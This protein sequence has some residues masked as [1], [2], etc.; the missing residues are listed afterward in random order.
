MKP[1]DNAALARMIPLEPYLRICSFRTKLPAPI[2]AIVLIGLSNL[3][4]SV[5]SVI[6]GE[7][8]GVDFAI[9]PADPKKLYIPRALGPIAIP[10]QLPKWSIMNKVH[11]S[12]LRNPSLLLYLI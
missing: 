11:S 8:F 9:V 12:L 1:S 2:M 7:D 5:S 6:D 10:S 3:Y 4:G